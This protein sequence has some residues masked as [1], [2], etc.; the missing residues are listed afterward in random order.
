MLVRRK[1]ATVN[2]VALTE[3]ESWLDVMARNTLKKNK[4]HEVKIFNFK[5]QDDVGLAIEH[6]YA[7]AGS[8]RNSL[9]NKLIEKGLVEI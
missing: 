2:A 7:Q 3:K 4:I 1:G 6:D 5:A 9:A 8:L